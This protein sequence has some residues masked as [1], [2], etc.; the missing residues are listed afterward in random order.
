[1]KADG[2]VV[3]FFGTNGGVVLLYTDGGVKLI[4]SNIIKR[5]KELKKGN[6]ENC[7]ATDGELN[8]IILSLCFVK[9][10][11]VWFCFIFLKIFFFEGLF[12]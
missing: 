6:M 9:S 2:G 10:S 1:M 5:K 11:K 4:N 3:F 12:F 8:W 7:G